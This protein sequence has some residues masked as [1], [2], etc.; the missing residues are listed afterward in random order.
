MRLHVR[1]LA[2][3]AVLLGALVAAP[4]AQADQGQ[5]SQTFTVTS[6]P[7]DWT[8]GLT[9]DRFDPARGQLPPALLEDGRWEHPLGTDR[10]GRDIFD[11]DAQ[12]AARG[13]KKIVLVAD[14]A[15]HGPLLVR[16][17]DRAEATLP[18]L[19]AQV[20]RPDLLTHFL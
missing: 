2:A 11:Y 14:T 20:V 19:L 8:N 6:R 4:V 16:H 9:V 15:P 17:P 10:K 13:V 7:T 5:S 18:D 1:L 12:K 3:T